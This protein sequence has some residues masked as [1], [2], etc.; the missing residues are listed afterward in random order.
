MKKEDC[1]VVGKIVKKYSFKGALIIKLDTDQPELYQELDMVFLEVKGSLIPFFI[2]SCL[3]QRGDHLRV[4]FEDVYSEADAEQLLRKQ[5]YLPLSMLPDLQQDQF[6]YHEIIG[7]MLEDVNEGVVG[8]VIEVNDQSAQALFIVQHN[9][10]K[11][12]VPMVDDFIKTIDKSAKKIVV[13]TPEGLI[14]MNREL[15]D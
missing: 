15:D 10:E 4:Q 1:F 14:S 11:I 3:S 9:E 8:K 5:V 12:L 2:E 13:E 7:F 6:Y